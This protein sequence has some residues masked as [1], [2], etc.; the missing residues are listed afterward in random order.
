M[1]LR[2]FKKSI[3]VALAAT[4]ITGTVLTGCG[5]D[6]NDEGLTADSEITVISREEGSGTR[7]AFVELMGVVD[8]DDKDIT[9]STSEITSSTSVM[10]TTVKDNVAAI[11]YVSLGSLNDTVK[12]VEVEG[13][14][15]SADN[16]KAGTY[17]A[18]RPFNIVTSGEVSDLTGDFID[19]ILSEEGQSIV[20]EAGY[21]AITTGEPYTG[22]PEGGK[23]VVSGSSSVTPVMEKIKE[24]YVAKNPDVTVEVQQS[25]SSTGVNDALDGTSNIGMSSRN[26]KESEIEKGAVPTVIAMDGIAV[27]VNN[28]N[29]VTNL[30]KEQVKSIFIG[31]TVTWDQ[32]ISE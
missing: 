22:R 32:I 14:T 8:A 28:E 12:A 13:V 3:M 5:S 18:A 21:I 19:F 2:K 24:A 15:A 9:V 10:L 26:L 29:P 1:K 20:E 25:D 16:I 7:S 31:E 6:G 30:T 27:I 11:G 4:M 23:I 17:E